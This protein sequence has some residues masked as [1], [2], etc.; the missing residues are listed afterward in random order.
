VE[1]ATV[2]KFLQ[3]MAP[4]KYRDMA[5]Q[6]AKEL[7]SNPVTVDNPTRL[8]EQSKSYLYAVLREFNDTSFAPTAQTLLV[9]TDGKIDRSALAY[10][11]SALKEGAVSSLYQA[12]MDPRVTNQW[13]KTSILTTALNYAGTNPQANEMFRSVVNGDQNGFAKYLAVASLAGGDFGPVRRDQPSDPNVIQARIKLLDTVD[14][15]DER[16]SQIVTRT[17]ENLQN[18]LDGKPVDNSFGGRI[19]G[20]GPGGDT[21]GRRNRPGQ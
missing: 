5:I 11:N 4:N 7:L 15:T 20:G 18:I 6:A 14:T 16:F 19:R 17:K 2:A 10:L 21:G 9:G 8:D 12:Y 3:E 13:D 1:V